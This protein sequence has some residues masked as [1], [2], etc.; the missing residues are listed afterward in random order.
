MIKILLVILTLLFSTHSFGFDYARES[1]NC[2]VSDA[3]EKNDAGRLNRSIPINSKDSYWLKFKKLIGFEE[4]ASIH[5][6]A[7]KSRFSINRQSGKI[8][9]SHISNEDWNNQVVDRGSREQSLK[10]ISKSRA[11]YIHMMYLQ[12]DLYVESEKKPFILI[13]GSAI[14][15]GICE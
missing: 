10:I 15:S 9:G 14:F 3:H 2:I 11:G 12:A 7:I 6:D 1:L 13:D 8:S 5:S 4:S